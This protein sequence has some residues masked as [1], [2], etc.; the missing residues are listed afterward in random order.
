L[1]FYHPPVFKARYNYLIEN[2]HEVRHYSA[3][4][5]YVMGVVFVAAVGLAGYGYYILT[6]KA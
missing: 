5:T 1:R 6:Y 3:L 2:R 4:V